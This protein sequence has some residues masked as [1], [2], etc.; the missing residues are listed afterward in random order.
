ML[1]TDFLFAKHLLQMHTFGCILQL[2][3]KGNVPLIHSCAPY[4]QL[5][6]TASF[7]LNTGFLD[8]HLKF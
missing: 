5:K 4:P 1:I 2:H 6:G 8:P 3:Y 7:I